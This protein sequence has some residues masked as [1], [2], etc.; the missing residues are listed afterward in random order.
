MNERERILDLVKQGVLSTEEGLDLLESLAKKEDHKQAKR[1]FDND[2]G[3][4]ASLRE[5]PREDEVEQELE[6]LDEELDRMSEEVEQTEDEK[7]QS[8]LEEELEELANE[9][10]QYSAELDRINED[11]AEAKTDLHLAQEELK[12]VTAVATEEKQEEVKELNEDLRQK[13]EE[14]D[15]VRKV[16]E[17]DN[18]E[19]ITEILNEIQELQEKLEE[20]QAVNDTDLKEKSAALEKDI[21]Q[22][23][24]EVEQ[25]QK[26]KAEIMRKLHSSKMKQWTTRAKQVS[27]KLEIPEAWKEEASDAFEKAGEQIEITGRDLG[28]FIR[29]T[30]QSAKGALENVEWTDMNIRVPKLASTEFEHE[31]TFE[32]STAT[33]LDFKN[34]NG[35]IKFKTSKTNDLTVTAKIKLYGKMEEETP[36]DA[37]NARSIIEEDEDKL[38]FHVPN[39]RIAAEIIVSLPDRTYDYLAAKLLNGNVLFDPIHIKDV[40]IQSTNGNITFTDLTAS[41]LETKATNGTISIKDAS[42]RDLL[43]STVNGDVRF[44]GEAQ[45]S[46]VST[47]NGEVRFTV[48]GDTLTR[49]RTTSVNG[50]V[51]V[52]IPEMVGIEGEAKSVFGKVKSRL[53]DM[54]G[55]EEKGDKKHRL[56]LKRERAGE[57]VDV[58]AKTTTGNVLLKDT[59]K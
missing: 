38:T 3:S 33:I 8:E 55:S 13:K 23:Q 57:P 48:T 39:K 35:N 59:D 51:K 54:S 22:Y 19:A 12:D 26:E 49:I 11:L 6:D 36:L 52:A 21:E 2:E 47:T 10:N 32:N 43:V 45:S 18:Y 31:W 30:I 1:E 34:A 9:V 44:K 46:D 20:A 28:G 50:N 37:F 14:L 42:L 24:K 56:V 58:S 7:V 4:T 40:Y 17:V 16:D 25:Y 53:S 29:E 5:E 41:M 27:K 15:L